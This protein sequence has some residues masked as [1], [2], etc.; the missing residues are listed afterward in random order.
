MLMAGAHK[1]H[2]IRVKQCCSFLRLQDDLATRSLD[3]HEGHPYWLGDVC[4]V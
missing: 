2:P 3:A 4:W 1:G